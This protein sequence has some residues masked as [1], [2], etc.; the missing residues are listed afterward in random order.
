[1]SLFKARELWSAALPPDEEFGDGGLDWGNV[2][3]S[4]NGHV[5]LVTGSL[6]GKLRVH[7]PAAALHS[8][9]LEVQL[10]APVLHLKVGR[11]VAVDGGSAI[12]VALLHPNKLVVFSVEAR[13]QARA[14]SDGGDSPAASHHDLVPRYS[15]RLDKGT[16][17]FCAFTLCLAAR[18]AGDLVL[19]Q[20]MDG[21]I[22]IYEHD[23]EVF[24]RKLQDCL[25]PGPLKY[26]SQIDAFVTCTSSMFVKCYKYQVLAASADA[27]GSDAYSEPPDSPK[28][29]LADDDAGANGITARRVAVPDWSF[30]I[31]EP[32][33][34]IET[35]RFTAPGQV[36]VLALGERTLFVLSLN[37]AL[38]ATKM[39]DFE[40]RALCVFPYAAGGG[41]GRDGRDGVVLASTDARLF[42]LSDA[43][44]IVW[45]ARGAHSDVC[46][47]LVVGVVDASHVPGGA[48][49]M[50]T[51]LDESNRLMLQY[52]GTEPQRDAAA[53]ER[54]PATT[55]TY[56]DMSRRLAAVRRQLP[57]ADKD[58]PAAGDGAGDSAPRV[59]I[60]LQP[61]S[62]LD[63]DAGPD[64]PVDAELA[65]ELSLKRRAPLSEYGAASSLGQRNAEAP[66]RAGPLVAVTARLYVSCTGDA[67]G[68]KDVTVTVDAPTWTHSSVVSVALAGVGG[69]GRSPAVLSCSFYART[70]APPARMTVNAAVCFSHGG[71][72]R[73]SA[74]SFRLPMYLACRLLLPPARDATFKLTLDSSRDAVPLDVLFQD[75]FVQ[76]GEAPEQGARTAV[77]FEYFFDDGGA[78]DGGAD[79]ESG[80][81]AP[82]SRA[83]ATATVLASKNSGRY[84]LQSTSF[85][86]LWLVLDELCSRLR[87]HWAD[88]GGVD[89]AYREPLP[90]S[91]L[92]AAVD[93]HHAARA[94]ARGVEARLNEAANQ[95]RVIEKRLLVRFKDSRPASLQQLDVLLQRTHQSLVDVATELEAAQAKCR[96]AAHSLACATQLL[97]I[98]MQL[99]FGLS[100]GDGE[101]LRSHLSPD[102]GG[103]NGSNVD[104]AAASWEERTD[105]ALTHLLKTALSKQAV[106]DGARRGD[107]LASARA[108]PGHAVAAPLAFAA[109]TEKFKRHVA[110]ACDRLER[111]TQKKQ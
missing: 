71:F 87:A 15:H 60:H 97:L 84:R 9:L 91:D 58:R 7:D 39:L 11:L 38:K 37:G 29:P 13:T 35:A 92:Y 72:P 93:A 57:S 23:A 98:L 95:Y 74:V 48:A 32:I 3:N 19:I 16:N 10:D 21:R 64:G 55:E 22:Q 49:G 90:L 27:A 4:E 85:A 61:P 18:D 82:V 46:N 51:V 34:A 45:A 107:V 69:A 33:H 36:D 86:T 105:A 103:C 80:D 101:A 6:G 24:S 47:A 100:Q 52:L 31:G 78:A 68:L 70:L 109:S 75:M 65:A 110:M 42:V 25:L 54:A 88:A 5:K 8:L 73:Y 20:S 67:A 41:V 77:S 59:L 89:L 106:A 2:D 94:K 40:P 14:A 26:V 62:M 44:T 99:R 83:P 53:A 30:N 12:G 66:Q 76:A 1:M 96:R 56:A 108:A 28:A 104:E 50:L 111:A 63:D 79:A 43:A 81:G 17:T 102:V